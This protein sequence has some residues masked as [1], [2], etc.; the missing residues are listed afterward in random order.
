MSQMPSTP[1]HS[2]W[3]RWSITPWRSPMPSPFGVREGTQV[4]LVQDA[5]APPGGIVVRHRPSI[6]A[7]RSAPLPCKRG[8]ERSNASRHA[9][10]VGARP[11]AAAARARRRAR[12]VRLHAR[13]RA[14][15]RRDRVDR[16]DRGVGGFEERPV[17]R[18]ATA[19]TGSG[20][21]WARAPATRPTPTC[22][23][24]GWN[25][26]GASNGGRRAFVEQVLEWARTW[27]ARSVILAVTESNDRRRGF[28]EHLGFVDTGERYPLREG[29]ELRVPRPAP[30]ALTRASPGLGPPEAPC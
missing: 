8:G 14:R 9:R 27:D 15:P 21:P 6:A 17:R 10:R 19:R 23:G 26:R 28:Y 7:A 24:C 16:L 1:S 22:T 12:R 4:D 11:R 2:R 20:W 13:A 3:S 29:S 5:L 18:R 25:P 30:R